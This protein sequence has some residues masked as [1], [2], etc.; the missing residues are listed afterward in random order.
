MGKRLFIWGVIFGVLVLYGGNSWA[1]KKEKTPKSKAE[2]KTADRAKG[3]TAQSAAGQIS[4]EERKK[5]EEKV[6]G[7]LFSKEWTISLTETTA[8]KPKTE[9]DVLNFKE[10]KFN[11]K[12]LSA[13]GFPASNFTVTVQDDGTAVWETMQTA[14]K[15]DMASWRG[16]IQNDSMRGILSKRFLKGQAQDYYFSLVS[17]SGIQPAEKENPAEQ[18]KAVKLEEKVETKKE[19]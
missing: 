7:I 12:N 6:R 10:G 5:A 17:A 11:S 9:I 1:A 8:K 14:E 4:A 15:G 2:S 18:I 19:K 3:E 16:E 13:S